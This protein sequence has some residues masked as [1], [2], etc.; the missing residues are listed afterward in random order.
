MKIQT[1][2]Y[3]KNFRHRQKFWCVFFISR[4][5]IKKNSKKFHINDVMVQ[6]ET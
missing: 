3:K 5:Y 4:K 1:E 2:N 6:S